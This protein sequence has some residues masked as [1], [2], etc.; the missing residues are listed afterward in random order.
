MT[1]TLPDEMKDHLDR[2]AKDSGYD[3][4]DQYVIG[5]LIQDRG[6]DAEDLTGMPVPAELVIKDRADFEAKILE[7]VNSGPG[8]RVTP[9]FWDNLRRR[10]QD[11]MDA[12]RRAGP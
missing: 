7:G 2:R 1:I 8:V 5:L 3:T 9:E 10:V 6:E 12:R 4:I 11:K